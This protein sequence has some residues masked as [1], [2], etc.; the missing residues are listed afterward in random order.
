MTLHFRHFYPHDIHEINRVYLHPSSF[1]SISVDRYLP[2]NPY[3]FS[4][5]FPYHNFFSSFH[6]YSSSTLLFLYEKLT[7]FWFTASLPHSS[8]SQKVSSKIMTSFSV[9]IYFH[10]NQ[11]LHQHHFLSLNHFL[12]P[13]HTSFG[14]HITYPLHFLYRC[15][16]NYLHHPLCQHLFELTLYTYRSQFLWL[17][18]LQ[19]HMLWNHISTALIP[20]LHIL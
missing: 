13:Q 3:S 1:E 20:N 18:F 12:D 4:F 8:S 15:H 2:S 5:S 10:T 7:A 19:L 9:P 14:H 16:L 6:P 11:L 17:N